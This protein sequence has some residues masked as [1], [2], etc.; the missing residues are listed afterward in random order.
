MIIKRKVGTALVLSLSFGL[1]MGFNA[2]TPNG[3]EIRSELAGID[4]ASGGGTGTVTPPEL[5]G[6]ALYATN[7]AGCHSSLDVT[8][9]KDRTFE[10][11][12]GAISAVTQMSYI[13]NALSSDELRAIASILKSPGEADGAG[14]VPSS[15]GNTPIRRLSRIEL[16]NSLVD[17]VGVNQNFVAAVE[18]DPPGLSGFSNDAKSLT[19][20]AGQLEKIMTAV[21]LAVKAG[22]AATNS[23]FLKCANNVQDVNCAR[24]QLQSF[25]RK[26]YRRNL[27]AIELNALLTVYTLNQASGFNTALSLAMQRA[28][29]SPNFMY[30][31]AFS[32]GNTAKGKSLTSQEFASRMA[33][34]LWNSVP[35]TTLLD[36]ADQGT[37]KQPVTLRAQIA[38]MLK[39]PK[40]QRFSDN[41]FKEWLRYDRVTDPTLV[42]RNGI[43]TQLRNDMAM[44]TALFVNSIISEDKSLANLVTAE[45]TYVNASMASHYGIAGINGTA[46]QKVSL[47]GTGRRGIAS[48]A[49]VLTVQANVDDSRPVARGFFL[50][51]KIICETPPPPPPDVDTGAFENIDRSKLTIREVM[52]IHRANPNCASC[53]AQMDPLGLSL[54]NY[55]QLG[56]YRTN[57][58]GGKSVDAS[59]DVFQKTFSNYSDMSTILAVQPKVRS[60][61]A[62]HVL[63]YA[64]NRKSGVDEK[65][66]GN[67]LAAAAVQDGSKLS[68]LIFEV[69]SNDMFNYN[70][71]DSN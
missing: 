5:D 24:T 50:L 13:K 40:A 22:L 55:N 16:Q 36:L 52:A 8:T 11:I 63:S 66:M 30:I 43:T 32:G 15:V 67:K 37:L 34:F 25:A 21:E 12:N 47:A 10:Q 70:V 1:A 31:T 69:M 42:I 56:Q 44:E 53:H 23:S 60:C 4:S 9:K 59:G 61:L 71:S 58:T 7:C 54:E 51:D 3:F 64:I 62:S 65:C 33:L 38:R 14:C 27:T 17:L 26:A 2:C 35:D 28:L 19:I 45:Y 20:G 46:F 68:D 57:Y 41:M 48:Q 49:S 6:K 29:L 39:D 18:I